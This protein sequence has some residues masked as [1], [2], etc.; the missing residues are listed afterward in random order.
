L[1]LYFFSVFF[2]HHFRSMCVSCKTR[3]IN[4]VCL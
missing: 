1:F 3:F 4:F 2:Q